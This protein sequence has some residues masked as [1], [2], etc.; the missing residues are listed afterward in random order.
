MAINNLQ[1]WFLVATSIVLAVASALYCLDYR[2][3]DANTV[4]GHAAILLSNVPE[5]QRESMKAGFENDPETSTAVPL[6]DFGEEGGSVLT[7]HAP[8]DASGRASADDLWKEA[9]SFKAVPRFSGIYA[10]AGLSRQEA[11]IGGFV[12]PALLFAFACFLALGMGSRSI[13]SD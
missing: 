8:R 6:I 9:H 11:M 7:W 1:R 10:R 13:V 4:E 12:V 5:A 3:V 2:V